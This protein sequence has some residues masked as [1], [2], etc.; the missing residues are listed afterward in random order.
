ME[1]VPSGVVGRGG[2]T[3][4]IAGKGRSGD[5]TAAPGSWC[6]C[7]GRHDSPQPVSRPPKALGARTHAGPCNGARQ[8]RSGTRYPP[9]APTARPHCRGTGPTPLV[10]RVTCWGRLPRGSAHERDPVRGVRAQSERV[11]K[12]GNGEA[13][14]S[15]GGRLAMAQRGHTRRS[16]GG[17]AD[18]APVSGVVKRPALGGRGGATAEGVRWSPDGPAGRG[19]PSQAVAVRA[20]APGAGCACPTAAGLSQSRRP[21]SSAPPPQRGSGN[22]A[23]CGFLSPSARHVER[24]L[25]TRVW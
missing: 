2:G 6:Q 15:R 7:R 14:G 13:S 4:R 17:V 3:K 1:E 25:A 8:Q 22:A 23:A 19:A 16:G 10:P 20:C 18:S 9:Q 21:S 5:G 11:A 24:G 12:R